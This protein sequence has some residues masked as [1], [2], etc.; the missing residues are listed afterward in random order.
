MKTRESLEKT[1]TC[2]TCNSECREIELDCNYECAIC[3]A[4]FNYKMF[5][6]IASNKGKTKKEKS[7][8]S[9]IPMHLREDILID[10]T[11]LYKKKYPSKK[12]LVKYLNRTYH[13]SMTSTVF[14][15]LASDANLRKYGLTWKYKK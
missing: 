10:A 2:L 5:A 13:T 14:D 8:V 7:F 12:E 15:M 11:N 1:L 3:Q 6:K 9:D 4:K